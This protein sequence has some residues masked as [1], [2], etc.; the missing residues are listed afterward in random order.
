MTSGG[1]TIGMSITV[2]AKNLPQNCRRAS[3]YPIG[4]ATHND[5]SAVMLHEIMLNRM[6]YCISGLDS[7]SSK[8]PGEVKNKSAT[9]IATM[10]TIYDPP[11]IA[12]HSQK[13]ASPFQYDGLATG[14]EAG[15]VIRDH[16]CMQIRR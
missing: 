14:S 7:A 9:S 1:N 11:S 6:A 16:S 8:C 12:K 10:R 2:S 13:P 4:T 15:F 3:K 5:R